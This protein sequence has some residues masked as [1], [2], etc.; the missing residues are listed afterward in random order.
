MYIF[1]S[2][3]KIYDHR[4]KYS[5]DLH[6]LNVMMKEMRKEIRFRFIMAYFV[7]LTVFAAVCYYVIRFSS[8]FG[9]KIS[10]AWFYSGCGGVFLNL[11]LYDWLITS[12]HWV[13]LKI[14]PKLGMFIARI[15]NI[16]QTREEA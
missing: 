6:T 12:I 15:R 10:W 4:I 8:L 9:W 11:T 1:A 3:F 16:K 13:I 14:V 2:L 5:A 7:A